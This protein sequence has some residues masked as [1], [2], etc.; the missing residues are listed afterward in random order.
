MGLGF[1]GD[2]I[3]M[4]FGIGC[5]SKD[6]GGQW[7]VGED[8]RLGDGGSV[9]V[10]MAICVVMHGMVGRGTLLDDGSA[11]VKGGSCGIGRDGLVLACDASSAMPLPLS[12][13]AGCVA[14][15]ERQEWPNT[16]HFSQREGFH[17]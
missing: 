8:G 17:S 11:L 13:L 7:V 10:V 1:D 4:V 16:W 15:I 14:T 6:G 3:G 9:V 2:E 5:G 12:M